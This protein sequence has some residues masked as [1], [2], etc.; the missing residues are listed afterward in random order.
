MQNEEKLKKLG[1]AELEIMIA[2]WE[3]AEPATSGEILDSIKSTR[4][5]ALSTLMASL[6]RLADKGYVN[7]DR[8]T[9]TNYYTALISAEEYK[10]AESRSFINRLYGNSVSR[11]VAGLYNSNSI[12]EEDIDELRALLDS[13]ERG[14]Q[15][16]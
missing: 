7:C 4:N 11:L 16:A 1:E 13:I 9:R 15:D 2:L 10:S 5:W 6:Q 3:K 8:S 14:E 12:T